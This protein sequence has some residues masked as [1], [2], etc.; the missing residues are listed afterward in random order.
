MSTRACY[1]FLQAGD[2]QWGSLATSVTIYGH[3][4]GYPTG[5]LE[6][7][8]AVLD[9]KLCWELPRFEASD[10]SAGFVAANKDGGGEIYVTSNAKAHGDLSY[11]YEIAFKNKHIWVRCF[12]GNRKTKKDLLFDGSLADM[13]LRVEQLD[14]L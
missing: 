6:K 13:V 3:S 11:L 5:A 14:Q 4:D 9:Q 2:S 1:E 10:F 7:I 8:K 12:R